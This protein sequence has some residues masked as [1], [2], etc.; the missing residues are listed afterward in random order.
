MTAELIG[1]LRP[2]KF[3]CYIVTFDN[4]KEFEEHEKIS[5]EL[6]A[7]VYLVRPPFLRVWL[8]RETGFFG[9][10]FPEG[11]ALIKVAREKVQHAAALN[12]RPR[13]ILALAG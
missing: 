11:M 9:S 8:E 13:K 6:G 2:H 5:V 4:G 10:I 12:H 3:K 7:D 1:L